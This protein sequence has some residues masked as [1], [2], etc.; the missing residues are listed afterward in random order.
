[1]HGRVPEP[2]QSGDKRREDNDGGVHEGGE[3]A[4]GHLVDTIRSILR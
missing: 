1:M 2:E 3:V 4:I